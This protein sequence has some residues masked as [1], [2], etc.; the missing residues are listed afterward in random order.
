MKI[1]RMAG[2]TCI[3]TGAAHGIA[4]A[5]ATLFAS[6]GGH[7]VLVDRDA[8]AGN[9]VAEL[10]RE[11]KQSAEFV[12]CDVSSESAVQNMVE[13]AQAIGGGKIDALINVAGVDFIAKLED[14]ELDRWNRAWQVNLT[15]MFLTSRAALP[16]MKKA[17][18]SSIVNVSS[19]QAER[20]FSGYPA[21]A[22]TKGGA[23]SFSKQLAVEYA[24]FGIRVN[25]IS[26]GPVV[27]DLAATS[28]ANEPDFPPL[29]PAGADNIISE[30]TVVELPEFDPNP[31]LFTASKP[32]DI[33][34]PVLWLA[35]DEAAAITGINLTVDGGFTVK[36]IADMNKGTNPAL[37]STMV[38]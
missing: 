28:K 22:A 5:V 19:I 34:Y 8:A 17:E 7:V 18:R 16:Y 29:G 4:K 10:L 36:G 3:V 21:Y 30:D 2:K 20:G 25:A 12:E 1:G 6:E 14:T 35:S 9:R 24:T 23:I 32:M 31:R 26:P 37:A 11:R 15:S 13:T 38:E 27:T 33:A